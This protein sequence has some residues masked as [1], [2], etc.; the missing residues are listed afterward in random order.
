MFLCTKNIENSITWCLNF[1]NIRLPRNCNGILLVWRKNY[2]YLQK[3]SKIYI[4]TS[5]S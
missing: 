4:T 2:S 5:K 3:V 1:Q